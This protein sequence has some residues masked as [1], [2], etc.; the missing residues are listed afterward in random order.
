MT[1]AKREP[2]SN[3]EP[4][5]A[6]DAATRSSRPVWDEDDRAQRF[7]FDAADWEPEYLPD[8]SMLLPLRPRYSLVRLPKP[9]PHSEAGGFF[10]PKTRPHFASPRPRHALDSARLRRNALQ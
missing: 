7:V 6:G 8:G 3:T 4:Q 2:K 1:T 5:P 9:P 10:M